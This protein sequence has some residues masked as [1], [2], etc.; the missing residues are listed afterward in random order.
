MTDWNRPIPS[1]ALAFFRMVFGAMMLIGIVRFAS[2]GWIHDLYIAPSFHFTY[3]GFEWVKV[4]P[5]WAMYAIFGVM[6][7]SALGILLGAYYRLS[8]WAF[9]LSFTYV[10]LI[11]KA[12]YLNHYYFVSIVALLMAVLPAHANY[13][14]DA[15]CWPSVRKAT[16][17]FW[18]LGA[19]R[20]QLALV[21]IYAG[22][23]K[24]Q[25]EW[26]LEAMPLKIWLPA[27]AHL[28]IVGPLLAMPEMAYAFSWGGAIY[29]CLIPFFLIDRRTRIWAYVAVVGFHAITGFL[30][31]IGMFPL[32]MIASTLSFFPTKSIAKTLASFMPWADMRHGNT[33]T[34]SAPLLRRALLLH[35]VFQILLPWRFLAYQDSVLWTEQGYRFSWRVMLTEKAGVATFYV[36]DPSTGNVAE[37]ANR[38]YLTRHQERMMAFQP[39][40]IL[41]FAHFLKETYQQQGFDAVEVRAKVLVSFNGRRA[42]PYIDENVDLA[43]EQ[44][45]F[46]AKH[47]IL[48]F[49]ETPWLQDWANNMD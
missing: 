43:K 25:P 36:K 30:F 47:W 33:T 26:L 5:P 32:V 12:N 34:N 2:M 18:M 46:A 3:W 31:P 29:D 6:A 23:A 21:Y 28:P 24:L 7:L 13:S 20:L 10:E 4:L 11:D 15:W 27:H 16:V 17:P 44:D 39:D 22:I 35:F 37:V 1:A 40:M 49:Q 48:P 8:A 19:I 42:Q 9:F 14:I 41:Q 45:T 38:Q